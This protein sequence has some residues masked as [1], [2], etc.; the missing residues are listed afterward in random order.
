MV[1]ILLWLSTAQVWGL[2]RLVLPGW[3]GSMSATILLGRKTTCSPVSLL[4]N[5][6]ALSSLLLATHSW[7]N[8]SALPTPSPHYRHLNRTGGR[9]L[10]LRLAPSR[11]GGRLRLVAMEL[12]GV[13]W[14]R[15]VNSGCRRKEGDQ[16]LNTPDG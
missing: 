12:R 2:P 7:P 13:V 6:P 16:V 1:Q 11:R 10:G 14:V 8:H 15:L 5:D 4:K 3:K 9:M